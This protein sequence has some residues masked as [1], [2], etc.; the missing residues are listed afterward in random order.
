MS[1]TPPA[2]VP[3]HGRHALGTDDRLMHGVIYARISDDPT[4]KA[5]GVERQTEEC[6]TLAESRGVTVVEELIDNDLSATS[7]KRRPSF[8]RVLELIR[9]DLIDTVVIWHTDRLYRLPRDLEPL[10]ELADTRPLRFLTVTASEID[11]NTSSGRMVARILAAASAAE[12]EHKVERQRS[13]SD[14]RASRGT[15]TARPG[16][17]YRRVDGRDVIHEPEGAVIREAARRVLDAESLRAIAA[18]F[19]ARAI[20]SPAGAP[21]QGVTLRQLIRRPSL[22]GLRVHRGH[23]VGEFD[24]ELHPAILDRSTYDRLTALFDDPTRSASSR[25]GHPPKHLLS[26]IAWCGRCGATLGGRM[27]RLAPWTPKPGQKS[28]PVKAAYAC[29]TCHKVRRLQAPVDELVTEWLL[30]RL[31]RDDTADLLTT[32]DPEAVR[33]AREAVDA[34]TARLASAAD[35]FAAGSIDGN[36]LARITAAGRAERE[37]LETRLTAALPTV[38]PSGAVGSGARAAWA[39]FDIHRRRLIIST[40][41]RVTILPTGPGRSFDPDLIRVDWLTA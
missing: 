6:R 40:L 30:Q 1:T 32:G 12:V 19:N 21:W 8:E 29:G 4:G 31:E 2:G 15:P 17:G 28:K 41:M 16:Y 20:P 35:L 27:V 26:G 36:Q 25:V 9:S 11:L 33:Q 24:F 38:L 14:Q 37:K 7:G 10:I 13:A 18:D 5:A 3:H 34:V 22:A 39:D 23:V